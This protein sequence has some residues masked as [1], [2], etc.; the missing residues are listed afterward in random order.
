MS[1]LVS[2]RTREFG[3][4]LALGASASGIIRVV[5][6]Q[7]AMLIATG[8]ILGTLAAIG[9]SRWIETLLFGV[10]AA[11]LSAFAPIVLLACVALMACAVPA[12]RATRVSPVEALRAD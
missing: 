9:L 4:R 7:G 1:Y 8:L 5:M 12:L 11:D 10:S 6:R 3:I 2:Q